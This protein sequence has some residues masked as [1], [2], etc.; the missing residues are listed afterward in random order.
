MRPDVQQRLDEALLL[1][2]DELCRVG[3]VAPGWVLERVEAGYLQPAAG[4]GGNWRF[5]AF[6]LHRVR[7]L[8]LLEREFDA[9]P[10]LAALVAD[11]EDEIARLH[12]RLR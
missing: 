2:L 9:V 7:R 10:E 6:A 4:S 8:A 1:T 11:L 5:D 12:R 3:T